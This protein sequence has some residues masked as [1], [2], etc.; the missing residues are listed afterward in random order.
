MK[1]LSKKPA[2]RFAST[3]A[4]SDALGAS[5][6]RMD[7]PKILHN[8]TRLIETP[9]NPIQIA[10][11]AAARSSTSCRTF[12][13]WRRNCVPRSMAAA[14]PPWWRSPS[15]ASCS[16]VR[17][18]RRLSCAVNRRLVR[19]GRQSSGRLP[20]NRKRRA[21]RRQHRRRIRP[22]P[23]RLPARLP[24]PSPRPIAATRRRR[25][26]SASNMPKARTGCRATTSKPSSG[27]ARPPTRARQ[28]AKPISAT[29]ISSAAAG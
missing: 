14:P 16:F 23:R 12:R 26:S 29:C 27:I 10:P 1:A 4:F 7:A 13:G 24:T 9:A 21:S 2:Q 5:A 22:R 3:R 18:R 19:C 28:G 8:D 11:R 20:P 6:M 17:H 25:T 15:S